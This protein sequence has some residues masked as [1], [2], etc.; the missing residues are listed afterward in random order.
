M[1]KVHLAVVSLVASIVAACP[2][3]HVPA[4]NDDDG[5]TGRRWRDAGSAADGGPAHA[6]AGSTPGEGEGE[7]EGE[8]DAGAEDAG[9]VQTDAGTGAADAGVVDAGPAPAGT[10]IEV[11]RTQ[12][13]TDF[14]VRNDV[15]PGGLLF[16]VWSRI[17]D[18]PPASLP[19]ERGNMDVFV[20]R[21]DRWHLR[22]LGGNIH[23]YSTDSFTYNANTML[24]VDAPGE[25][26]DDY[27]FYLA[28]PGIPEAEL[29]DWVWLAWQVIVESDAFRI[30]Q[31]VKFGPDRPVLPMIES[32]VTFDEVRT[33]LVSQRGWSVATATAWVPGP[34]TGF[35]V[36]SDHG[37]LF[38]ARVD[39][40]SGTPTQSQLD[41]IAAAGAGDATAWADYALTWHDGAAD[42]NDYSG[43]SRHLSLAPGGQLHQGVAPPQ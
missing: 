7:G 36:G 38:H 6:D 5:G 24:M 9:A 25:W 35:Q 1:R 18:P 15:P 43:H 4:G 23:V 32:R 42:L 12:W 34:A 17:A 29:H 26:V 31:W 27:T 33:T 20:L 22:C 40:T 30:R 2:A 39:A 28:N 41:A 37:Y 10:S 3:A 11:G 16:S 13:G 19:W 14:A 21:G 8:G